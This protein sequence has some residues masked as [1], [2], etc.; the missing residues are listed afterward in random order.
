MKAFN[1]LQNTKTYNYFF[2]NR[3]VPWQAMK[4]GGEN[5]TA[6]SSKLGTRRGKKF[7]S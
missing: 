2:T 4:V 3:V 5:I 6:I 7:A 1:S